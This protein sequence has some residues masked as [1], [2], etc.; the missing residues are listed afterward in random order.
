MPAP[1][2]VPP[3]GVDTLM[4][5]LVERSIRALI[6]IDTGPLVYPVQCVAFPAATI[7]PAIPVEAELGA[8]VV[9]PLALIM[10]IAQLLVFGRGDKPVVAGAVVGAGC[11]GTSVM[12]STIVFL[13][14]I[15]VFTFPSLDQEKAHIARALEGPR[16]VL[17]CPLLAQ[18]RVQAFIN[19]CAGRA[20]LG[21]L[22]PWVAP[23]LVGPDSVQAV[24]VFFA[25]VLDALVDIKAR[26]VDELEAMLALTLVPTVEVEA[27]SMVSAR[28]RALRAF[29]DISAVP[30]CVVVARIAGALVSWRGIDAVSV[31]AGIAQAALVHVDTAAFKDLE[32][33]M[34][35]ALVRPRGVEA[36]AVAAAGILLTLVHVDAL[37]IGLERRLVSRVTLASKRPLTVETLPVPADARHLLALIH[38]QAQLV[39]L[40][41]NVKS[42][43]APAHVRPFL[44]DADLLAATVV[45]GA[46]VFVGAGEPIIEQMEA[47]E[48]LAVV[49]A[50]RV[51]AV[52]RA[53]AVVLG[54]LIHI[55]AVG[56]DLSISFLALAVSRSWCVDTLVGTLE[57]AVLA[58]INIH[59]CL[60]VIAEV[61]SLWAETE[62]LV[63][64]VDADV[65]A[66]AVVLLTHV[67]VIARVVVRGQD[68]AWQG[69]T[70][71]SI[72]A[73]LI[74][75]GVLTGTVPVVE[76]ALVDVHT[77]VV[78]GLEAGV[79]G[80]HEGARLVDADPLAPAVVFPLAL[81]DVHA[82]VA[83]IAD[84]V[85]FVTLTLRLPLAVAAAL[86]F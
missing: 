34:A 81:V 37:L 45:N 64:A 21:E 15:I 6:H 46:L 65:R 16:E 24:T 83:V 14:F 30:L 39:I 70:R 23:A 66:S 19:I 9:F 73:L 33:F 42:R 57:L 5:T 53:A 75:A 71:A 51:D 17:A 7:E 72:A 32:A 58:L 82:R 48:A 59:A 12:A 3:V 61:K 44:V 18:V 68:S 22:V 76:E 78:L 31:D 35:I 80:T 63:V 86:D 79:A 60:P 69:F 20:L 74:V 29:V 26:V 8:A 56:G 43:V 4:L 11:V 77:S 41:V 38:V 1:A 84:Q 28:V 40:V 2:A 36:V 27:V 25:D 54:T 13:T 62:H 10:V 49:R 50:C 47:I 85:A 52:L 55:C 67:H